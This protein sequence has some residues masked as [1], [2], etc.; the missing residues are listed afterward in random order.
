MAIID[1]LK[2]AGEKLFGSSEAKAAP[3]PDRA[4]TESAAGAA[5]QK[6]LGSLGLPT[7]GIEVSFDGAS[8]V[9][10][11]SGTCKDQETKEKILLAAGNVAGV[12]KVEDAIRVENPEP[13]ARYY[14]VKKGDTLS[15]IAK[16]HYGDANAYHA[17][18]EA[19][20]PML[21]HPDKIYPG[22]KLRIPPRA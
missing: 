15:K 20:R 8:A 19:N 13:E 4:G 12:A 1:F 16:E 5:I 11:I 14:E 22:Q 2:D 9:C 18:F 6:Y 7:Q 10:R 17:I 3:A 21:K